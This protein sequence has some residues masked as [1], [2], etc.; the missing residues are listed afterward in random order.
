M[1]VARC[2]E[3]APKIDRPQLIAIEWMCVVTSCSPIVLPDIVPVMA[4]SMLPLFMLVMMSANPVCTGTP[5]SA[6]IRSACGGLDVRMRRVARSARLVKGL[7][8]KTT[9]AG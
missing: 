8:Q 9:C 4:H 6:S 3:S 2:G 1:P 5:P 7:L